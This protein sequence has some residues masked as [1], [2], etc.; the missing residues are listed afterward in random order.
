M[1]KTH[2]YICSPREADKWRQDFRWN[3]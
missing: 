3:D 1:I 2:L